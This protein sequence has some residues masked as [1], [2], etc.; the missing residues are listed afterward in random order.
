[1]RIDAAAP[2]AGRA[3]ETKNDQRLREA[4][5]EFEALFIRQILKGLRKTVPGGESRQKALYQSVLDDELAKIGS[6][7]GLGLADMLYERLAR[8]ASMEETPKDVQPPKVSRQST[9]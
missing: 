4:C 1:M 6:R 2:N 8:Y 3:V 7:R 9:D 5:R